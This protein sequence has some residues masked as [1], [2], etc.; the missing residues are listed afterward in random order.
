MAF[1]SDGRFLASGSDSC[2]VKIWDVTTG[3]ELAVLPPQSEG[4]PAV[5]GGN[6]A[7]RFTE[8]SDSLVVFRRRRA[9][10]SLSILFWSVPETGGPAEL[11][12]RLNEVELESI[13][14]AGKVP[15]PLQPRSGTVA[16][17]WLEYARE[18]LI[19]FDGGATLAIKA[20][21]IH[22]TLFDLYSYVP[23]A[24][25]F[26]PR[27]LPALV[28]RP[29]LTPSGIERI[30]REAH[31]VFG[32]SD[33][34]MDRVL[35]PYHSF[36]FSVDGRSLAVSLP[37]IG[38]ALVDASSGRILTTHVPAVHRQ[39]IDVAYTPDGR[40]IVMA[41]FDPQIHVWRPRP[42]ALAGHAE[43]TWSPAFAP[44]AS[45]PG[46]A[47]A[48]AGAT[49]EIWSLAFAPDATSLASAADDHTIKLWDVA[50]GQERAT[51]DG[52]TSLVTA[53]VRSPD[54]AL[55][56]SASFDRTIRLWDAASGKP[57]ATLPGHADLAR[58]VA[59]SPDALTLASA[60]DDRVIRRWDVP[61]RRELSPPLSGHTE[62]VFAVAFSPDGTTLFSGSDDKTIR[63]W[64]WSAG[65]IKAVWRADDRVYSLAVSPDGQ[66]L[67]AAHAGGNV[68]LW[69]VPQ[70]KAR[71]PLRGHVG[72]VLGLAFSPDGLTL[73]SAGRDRTVRLWDPVT[74]QELLTLHGHDSPVHGVA[75]SQGGTILA[76]G[77]HDGKIKLW[78]AA[79]SQEPLA[80]PGSPLRYRPIPIQF[81]WPSL[82]GLASSQKIGLV[83]RQVTQGRSKRGLQTGTSS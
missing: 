46:R 63:S 82:I 37:G 6:F 12:A 14:R 79:R 80:P 31:C 73:A 4:A 16:A 72:D 57:L 7:L 39:L 77:S 55:L 5:V 44:R 74:A 3:R 58:A 51:L 65:R 10:R 36:A 8:T 20:D 28:A 34:G 2:I 11:Q 40:M 23:V 21:A 17:P 68:T 71:P 25:V 19:M 62:K 67:A 13:G 52:H 70:A 60:G 42:L 9:P 76:T 56:A 32:P 29:E 61:A 78:R 15:R 18:H 83:Q 27:D 81:D 1:S 50:T 35:G 41:G 38:A 33:R 30:R 69:D 43:E 22:A 75:F 54:N 45:S 47:A 64:D 48:D 24:K 49:P 26:G 59:F 66:T 53:V